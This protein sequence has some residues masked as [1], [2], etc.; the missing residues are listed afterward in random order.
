MLYRV[1]R[2]FKNIDE[3][4]LLPGDTIDV[5]DRRA[6]IL[7]A[8]GLIAQISE[9]H[10]IGLIEHVVIETADEK[11]SEITNILEPETAVDNKPK[12]KRG[13]GKK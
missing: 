10:E 1:I 6:A 7:K 11:K 8:N 9:S 13:R 2:T 3:S 12:E 5:P 4:T